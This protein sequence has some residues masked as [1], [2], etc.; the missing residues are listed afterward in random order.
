MSTNSS[1]A[2]FPERI[3]TSTFTDLPQSVPGSVSGI[4]ERELVVLDGLVAYG[5]STAGT[6]IRTVKLTTGVL[7]R[8]GSTSGVGL[9]TIVSTSADVVATNAVVQSPIPVERIITSTFTDLPQSVPGSIS[10]IAERELVVLDG[11]VAYGSETAG[12]GIRSVVL[13]NGIHPRNGSTSGSG[14]RTIV[15]T[16]TDVV[17]T[18]SVVQSPIPVERIITST[19]TDLPQSIPGSTAGIGKR[20]L[21]VLD[22]LVAYGSTVAGTAEREVKS[23]SGNLVTVGARTDGVVER[24]ITSISGFGDLVAGNSVLGDGTRRITVTSNISQISTASGFGKRTVV[25]K[26][27]PIQGTPSVLG[28]VERTITQTADNIP[29]ASGS[30]VDGRIERVVTSKV[31][32]LPQSVPGST[33]GIATRTITI[34][35]NISQTSSASGSGTRTVKLITSVSQGQSRVDGI[36]QASTLSNAVDVYVKIR[37]EV[38]IISQVAEETELIARVKAETNMK[39]TVEDTQEI[40]V[41]IKPDNYGEGGRIYT[42]VA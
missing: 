23:T 6:G 34:T 8:N 24:E 29:Q 11:L 25:S 1:V 3:I 35:T 17:A 39:A 38:N 30:R 40:V 22:G 9:R 28:V 21:V 15:S 26:S 32:A 2:S 4:A 16:S 10:G 13:V 36:G 42:K 14:K 31:A 37:P 12:S 19:F 5:S 27:T 41:K 7:P 33:S 18:T 20:E